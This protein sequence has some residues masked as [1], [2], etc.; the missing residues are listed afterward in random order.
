MHVSFA[1]YVYINASEDAFGHTRSYYQNVI[2][3]AL[4]RMSLTDLLFRK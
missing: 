2:I 3:A 1:V 4:D